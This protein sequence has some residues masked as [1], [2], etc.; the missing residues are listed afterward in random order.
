MDEREVTGKPDSKL[1]SA[2]FRSVTLRSLALMSSFNYE[3]MQALG[4]LYGIGRPLRKIYAG[5]NEG[6]REAMRRHMAAF[7]MTC[8]PS[9]F[10]MGIAL[11][12]E[13]MYAADR[14]IDRSGVNAIKV[15]LMG[16]LS[17]IGD[18]FFWGIFRILACSLGVSFA[19]QGNP[20]AP[21]ILLL[22]FNV[23][24][25]LV[26]WF[27]VQLGYHRGSELIERLERGGQMKL[28]T[29][30]A[31]I[32]GAISIGTMIAMWVSITCP[33][34]FAIGDMQ[35]II[36]EYLDQIIPKLLPLVA[37]L[38]VYGALKRNIK[39]PLIIAALV[40]LG[41]GLGVC[42]AVAM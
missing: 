31:G 30:C 41:F 26:R 16:P 28:V 39:V 1:T 12:M 11:A 13:E 6:L 17:G 22:V 9:T 29:H 25:M 15:S 42:G 18:T 38:S 2:D 37:T 4:F 32:I 10:V 34:T 27:G 5:D 7:N 36:Q 33:L 3:R 40:I 14:S 19:A 24:N 20:I 35:I 21:F 8:A 23:P